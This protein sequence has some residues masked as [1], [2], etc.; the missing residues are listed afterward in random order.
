[1]NKLLVLSL[2][3]V[4][5]SACSRVSTEPNEQKVLNAKPWLF[6]EGGVMDE[7]VVGTAYVAWSTD[8]IAVN[9]QPEQK[10]IE[11]ND[12]MTL[13]GVPVDFDAS[14][15]L[16]VTDS[17]ALV[18]RYGVRWYENNVQTELVA[19]VRDAVKKYGLNEIAISSTAAAKVDEEVSTRLEGYLARNKFPVRLVRFTVGKA[20]PPDAIKT[21][22]IAT[23]EQ[24]QRV[25]TL[26][27][28]YAAELKRKETEGARAEADQ[29]YQSK[30][31]L[32]SDQF[33]QLRTLETLSKVCGHDGNCTFVQGTGGSIVNLK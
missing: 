30:L 5:T 14:A 15:V 32:S 9:M 31:G 29:A 17:V 24:E 3:A 4:T 16:Q 23:S 33:V 8:A 22:R 21:Q 27:K 2:L 25:I 1:M 28:A 11:F 19:Y 10:T 13:D 18:R 20:N 7:P 12:L 6:G 26:Q